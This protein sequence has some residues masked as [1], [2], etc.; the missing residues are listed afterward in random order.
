MRDC[1]LSDYLKQAYINNVFSDVMIVC[2]DMQ[3]TA[4][5]CVLAA[6]SPFFRD[7]LSD[8]PASGSSLL[9]PDYRYAS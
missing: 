7:I 6:S 1:C 9:L 4:H 8:A 3:F 2:S 5:R